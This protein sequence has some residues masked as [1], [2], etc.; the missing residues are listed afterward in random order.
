ML[1]RKKIFYKLA[2]YA[3]FIIYGIILIRETWTEECM[4]A[5]DVDYISQHIQFADYFRKLFYSNG[6]HFGDFAAAIG[7]GQNIYSISYYGLF[8]PDVMI[9]LVL[10][11]LEMKDILV[12]YSI[13]LYFGGTFLFYHWVDEK[14]INDNAKIIIT[15]LYMSS[16]VLLQTHRQLMYV[17]YMPFLIMILIGI[18]RLYSGKRH[19]GKIIVAGTVL[20]ILHSYYFSVAS[21]VLCVAYLGTKQIHLRKQGDTWKSTILDKKIL[22]S[23]YLMFAGVLLT[24]FLLVPTFLAIVQSSRKSADIS[25]SELLMPRV[26]LDGLLENK[27]GCGFSFLCLALL[28]LGI[29]IKRTRFISGI[30]LLAGMIPAVSYVMSGFLYV[31]GKAYMPLIPFVLYEC[32]NVIDELMKE[33]KW[34][35][36]IILL[37]M[38]LPLLKAMADQGSMVEVTREDMILSLVLILLCTKIQQAFVFVPVVSAYICILLNAHQDN[39]V[40]EEE[41]KDMFESYIA[42]EET[43]FDTDYRFQNCSINT[44]KNNNFVYDANL[45][46]T[47]VYASLI[48]NGYMNF[49]R[50]EIRTNTTTTVNN[51]ISPTTNIFFEILMGTRY[52]YTKNLPMAGYHPIAKDKNGQL[53]ENKDVLPVIYGTEKVVSEEYFEKTGYPLNLGIGMNYTV[54]EKNDDEALEEESIV[55]EVAMTE[56]LEL[57]DCDEGITIR[58]DWKR[59]EIDSNEMLTA[60]FRVKYPSDVILLNMDIDNQAKNKKVIIRVNRVK[61]MM[62]TEGYGLYPNNNEEFNFVL[63]DNEDIHEITIDF[64]EGTYNVTNLRAYLCKYEDISRYHDEISYVKRNA[65]SGN[66]VLAGN[67]TMEQD[68]YLVTS[69]PYQ[70]GLSLWIDGEKAEMEKVNT[71]FAGCKI[72]KGNHNVAVCYVAP[73]RK[74]GQIISFA[75]LGMLG[76][77]WLVGRKMDKEK[78]CNKSCCG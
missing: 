76:A 40:L 38:F 2:V 48:N 41:Y 64:Y 30:I 32:G 51:C 9:S 7:A 72:S 77:M 60:K 29:T 33:Q 14:N 59:I 3:V 39:L 52:V 67:I 50:N 18:D 26:L 74:V 4:Y 78:I 15:T 35:R 25:V 56:F 21:L 19:S 16:N 62:T 42:M 54:I 58:D 57:V 55:K 23:V 37:F 49:A 34:R 45:W 24:A 28:L 47:T 22:K 6:G 65:V 61:D 5:S 66:E 12:A 8:R 46:Q 75:G 13:F 71:A 17:N 69:I 43:D 1:S 73:G 36:N 70:A 20:M 11:F 31:N 53:Y 68:G 27:N 44:K 63:S 10:P